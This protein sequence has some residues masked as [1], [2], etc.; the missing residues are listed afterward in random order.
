[1]PSTS[2]LQWFRDLFTSGK[3]VWRLAANRMWA[4]GLY[5]ALPTAGSAFRGAMARTQGS[6]DT[7]RVC[8][9][10]DGGTTYEWGYLPLIVTTTATWDPGNITSGSEDATVVTFTGIT[11]KHICAASYDSVDDFWPIW[12]KADTDQVQVRIKNNSG[13]D[14]NPASGTVRVICFKL[15]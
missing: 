3:G 10:T 13:G 2:P 1:M 6:P 7:L 5:T 8:H 11:R 15:D 4:V 14:V 12:A 9:S